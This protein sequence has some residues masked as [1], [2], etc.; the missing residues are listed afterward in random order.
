MMGLID[1]V[2]GLFKDRREVLDLSSFND[3]LALSIDWK[4]LV[5]GGSNFCTHRLRKTSS[6]IED[7]ACFKVTFAAF[8]FCIVFAIVGFVGFFFALLLG[9]ESGWLFLI[10]LAVGA[11][12]LWWMKRK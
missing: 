3:P 5:G 2:F 4:P 9:D 8:L 6:F 1:S 7:L 10:F 12:M 11:G